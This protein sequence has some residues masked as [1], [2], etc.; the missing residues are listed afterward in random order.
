MYTYVKKI[1]P[2]KEVFLNTATQED[3]AVMSEHFMY[4]QDKLEKG[5]LLLAGPCEDA[6]FGIAI[7]YASSDEEAQ[8]FLNN[9]PAIIKGVM[10][11]EVH[12]YRLS[13]FKYEQYEQKA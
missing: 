12:R 13:L 9:D 10:T 6:A 7:F 3:W 5:K 2:T 11:G 4:L 8:E 1:T